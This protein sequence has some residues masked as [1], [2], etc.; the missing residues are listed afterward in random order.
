MKVHTFEVDLDGRKLTIETGKLAKQAGGS[1]VVRWGDS[2]VLV[3]ACSAERPKPNQGFFPLTCDYREY[4]YAAGKDPRRLHQARRQDVRKGN[5]HQP[6]DR[7]ADAAAV[8]GG[9]SHRDADHRHGP[10]GRSGARPRSPRHC[11]RRRRAGDFRY[12]VPPP[13]QR[14]ARRHD[15]RQ[16]HRE[17]HLHG[18]P[19]IE[20]QHDRGRQRP[21]AS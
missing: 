6:D 2:V 16:I 1:V 12:S 8:P 21:R 19:R 3:T 9:L 20:A 13:G 7:P 15:R 5:P 17:P 11:R 4:T 18:N 10:F 14:R